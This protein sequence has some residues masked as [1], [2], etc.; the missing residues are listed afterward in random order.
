LDHGGSKPQV[1]SLGNALLASDRATLPRAGRQAGI[2]SD[3]SA[4]VEVLVEPFGPEHG[5]K[6]WADSFQIHQ[7]RPWRWRS[8]IGRQS[9]QRIALSLHRLEV[10]EEEFKPVELASDLRL[11]MLR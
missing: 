10:L 1:A 7:H 6:L 2:G 9:E 5:R 8:R 11:E 4:I 3:L